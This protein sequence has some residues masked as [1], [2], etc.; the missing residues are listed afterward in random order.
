VDELGH[1]RAA[2]RVAEQDERSRPVLDGVAYRRLEVAPLRGAEVDEAVLARRRAG[3]VAVGDQERGQPGTAEGGQH[4]EPLVP[5]GVVAV[6]E[7]RPGSAAPPDLPRRHEPELRAESISRKGDTPRRQWVALPDGRIEGHVHALLELAAHVGDAPRDLAVR[8]GDDLAGDRV[9]ARIVEPVEAGARACV[10]T[11]EGDPVRPAARQVAGLDPLDRGAV[12][13]G[14]MVRLE[15]PR[16]EQPADDRGGG[17]EEQR[18]PDRGEGRDEPPA[19]THGGDHASRRALRSP[20]GSG[21][22]VAARRSAPARRRSARSAG[23]P[24]SRA[25]SA[26]AVPFPPGR[27]PGARPRTAAAG[28]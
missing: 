19:A 26:R 11:L 2:H 22:S 9:P 5:R 6:H 17:R 25:W 24:R 23:R 10:V 14:L 21:A 20:A 28:C 4:A 3:V 1:D 12:R 13:P 18:Q 7:D 16:G 15:Q 27:A 8:S